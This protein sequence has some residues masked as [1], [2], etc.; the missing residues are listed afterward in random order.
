MKTSTKLSFPP[1]KKKFGLTLADYGRM[2]IAQGNKCAICKCEETQ[3]GR[4]GGIKA[5]A[6][7]HDH[8]TGKVRGLLCAHCNA[9][10]GMLKENRDT[11]LSMIRYLDKYSETQ[12]V[13]TT[14]TVV[15]SEEIQS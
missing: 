8:V 1:W 13:V 5:L 10:M 7:D 9:S 15:P 12:H 14:L 2:V 6:V 3:K 4:G 11:L